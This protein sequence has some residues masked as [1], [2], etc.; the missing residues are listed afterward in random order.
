MTEAV[1]VPLLLL[2]LTMTAAL[3]V[4][5]CQAA[6]RHRQRRQ[7]N[8]ETWRQRRF[9][10]R[11]NRHARKLH[12]PTLLPPASGPRIVNTFPC[13]CEWHHEAGPRSDQWVP[14]Q[15]HADPASVAI[16]QQETR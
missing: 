8:T 12:G 5:L 13:G 10:R 15:Q 2:A 4:A 11:F 7:P 6:T 3:T 9:R 1:V 16:E 14:C